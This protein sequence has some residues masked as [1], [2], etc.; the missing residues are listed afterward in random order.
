MLGLDAEQFRRSKL[1]QYIYSQI[2][3]QEDDLIEQLVQAAAVSSDATCVQLAINISMHRMLPAFVS[4][5]VSSGRGA[6]QNLEQMEAAST[7]D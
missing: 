2:Q 7:E 1:G 6:E 5:A 3:L 4:E